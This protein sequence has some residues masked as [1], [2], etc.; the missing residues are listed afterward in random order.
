M[1]NK[2]SLNSSIFFLLI[3]ILLFSTLNCYSQWKNAQAHNISSDIIISY[4]VIYDKELSVEEKNSPEYLSEI[5]ISFNKDFMIQRNFGS[6]PQQI[7]T[8]TLLDYN[9]LQ[10]YSCTIFGTT[11]NAVKYDFIEPKLE[12]DSIPKSQ[13]TSIVDF[14]CK[15]GVVLLNNMEKDIYYTENIGLRYCRQFK[16]NGF[17]LQYPGYSKTLGYFTVKAKQILKDNFPKSMYSLEGFKITT[18][19]DFKKNKD[20]KIQEI[21]KIKRDLIGSKATNF[22]DIT[23]KQEK[24]DTKKLVGEIV[25][26]NFWFTNCTPCTV[27]IPKLNTLKEKYK[28]KNVHFIA[29]GLDPEYKMIP[30]F[31]KT[32]FDYDII[33]EGSWLAEKFDVNAYPTNIIVDQKGVIQF[34]EIGYKTDIIER[35]TYILD[36]YL[37]Q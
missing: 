5:L 2:F 13:T 34:Y 29:I 3:S 23:I 28:N 37:V 22:K 8:Y 11:K 35:M 30:F 19:E 7:N 25:V 9:T 4:E 18:A 17:L 21:N 1:K 15:K 12:V 14:A 10:A 16:I 27:E 26:Y 31:K 36:K 20:K 32:P 24:I 33:A 6:V